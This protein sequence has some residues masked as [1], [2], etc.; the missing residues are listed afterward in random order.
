VDEGDKF[1]S[2]CG[3]YKDTYNIHRETIKQRD[4]LFYGVLFVFA[5]FTSQFV[6]SPTVVP[7]IIEKLTG[8]RLENDAGFLSTLL[9][10]ALLGWSTRYFQITVEIQG[11][12]YYMHRLEDDL[13]GFYRGSIAFTREGKTYSTTYTEFQKWIRLLY[14]WLFPIGLLGAVCARSYIEIIR[15]LPNWWI[16]LLPAA[17]IGITTLLYLVRLHWNEDLGRHARRLRA[18]PRRNQ[19]TRAQVAEASVISDD[20]A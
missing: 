13:N 8:V 10:L 11:Q 16:D 14:T 4:R 1:S 19:P 2:L 6:A 12:Y 20:A 5:S 3:H 18:R 7:G 17:I 9:W 15:H